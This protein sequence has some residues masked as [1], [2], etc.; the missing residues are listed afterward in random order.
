M[1]NITQ[2]IFH[3]I[4]TKDTL[5]KP[6]NYEED[7]FQRGFDETKKF[8][9]NFNDKVDFKGKTVID[10]GCGFGST[11]IYMALNGAKKVI[12]ID[13][14]EK[15]INFARSNLENDYKNLTNIVN[16]RLTNDMRNENF[17]IVLSKDSFEHYNDPENFIF[18]MKKF[19]NRDG[20][21]VIGFSP[22]WKSPYGGHI[23]FMTKV[24]WAHL[25]FPESVIM[26]ERKRFRPDENAE[27]FEQVKGG[28]NKMTLE[29]YL[30]IIRESGLEFEFLRTNIFNR[31]S[32]A[33][34][35]N[36]LKKIPFCRGY[37]TVNVYSIIRSRK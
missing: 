28:L 3:F 15:R 5:E 20:I 6:E 36:I 19:L 34:L 18:E 32:I 31:R 26:C 24:P 9:N 22:L 25:L 7:Y 35:L 27:S 37:F 23:E 13:I 14:D 2:K 10:V 30:N 33:F 4:C 12:G 17:D 21:M 16:F 11:C 29:R 1:G 8:F